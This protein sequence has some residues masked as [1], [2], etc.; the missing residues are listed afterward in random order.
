L[1]SFIGII[2]PAD[3]PAE[4]LFMRVKERDKREEK[5]ERERE[6]EREKAAHASASS[7]AGNSISFT[8]RR[9]Y[10]KY[11]ARS[12][13]VA[14]RAPI[15]PDLRSLS[16]GSRI[17]PSLSIIIRAHRG[18]RAILER[19]GSCRTANARIRLIGAQTRTRQRENSGRNEA[20]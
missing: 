6:R 9:S 20:K 12:R 19:L 4:T 16:R 8:G 5:R 15:S 2:D 7:H 18:A 3:K 14:V 17:P 1:Y 11:S 13:V 10:L